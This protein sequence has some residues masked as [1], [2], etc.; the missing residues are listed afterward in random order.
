M[1]LRVLRCETHMIASRDVSDPDNSAILQGPADRSPSS[2]VVPSLAVAVA[3]AAATGVVWVGKGGGI[4]NDAGCGGG[5]DRGRGRGRGAGTT[6]SE[7]Q[8]RGDEIIVDDGTG[9]DEGQDSHKEG[10]H[11]DPNGVHF[12]CRSL[13]V[14][15]R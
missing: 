5:G 15:K 1:H 2:Q 4:E 7:G 11:E 14:L 6:V 3:W 13:M 10:G 12:D 9:A 8:G